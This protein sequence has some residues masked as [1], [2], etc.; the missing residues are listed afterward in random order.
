MEA[1]WSDVD[2]DME[3]SWHKSIITHGSRAQNCSKTERLYFSYIFSIIFEVQG[4]KLGGT[5]DLGSLLEVL[6]AS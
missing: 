1:S 3:P 2:A 4:S 6:G 5:L